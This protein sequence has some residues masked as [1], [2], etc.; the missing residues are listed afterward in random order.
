M[1]R[2]I[3]F[4]R[5][6][7]ALLL[8]LSMVFGLM[9]C[10]TP[11]NSAASVATTAPDNWP[12]IDP[13]ADPLPPP[14][15]EITDIV[16]DAT[17]GATQQQQD[18]PNNSGTQATQP[19][20]SKPTEPGNE[21][22]EQP[23]TGETQPGNTQPDDNTQ[24]GNNNQSGNNTQTE[25]VTPPPYNA[26][27]KVHFIDVGQADAALVVCQ[28]KTMLID[29]GNAADSNVMYAYLKKNGITHLDYV[30]G[31]HAHEDHIGG[32][33]G[34]LQYATVGKVY[35]PVTSYNSSAFRNFVQAVSNRGASITVP[36]VGTSFSLG[37]ASVKIIAVNTGS[38]PNNTSIVLRI[39]FG[40]TSFLFTGDAEYEVEQALVSSGATLKSTVLKVGHHGS[41]TSTKYSFLWHV[42]PEYAVI[43]VGKGNT[44]GHPTEDVLSRLRDAD[45]KLFRTDM[46]GDIICTSNGSS[47][48]F[49]VSRNANA[50]TFGGIGNNSTQTPPVQ[51]EPETQP[52][53][54]QP[55]DSDVTY[56]LNMG[57]M[58]FHEIYCE[59]AAKISAYNRFEFEGTR[60]EA[61]DMGYSPCGY[62][63]P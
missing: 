24:S 25:P 40:S 32:I 6:T 19:D 41:N 51:N 28:G 48:S 15:T 38:D 62:C 56:I 37:S 5:S 31:T 42:M 60:E 52:T 16:V 10:G 54:T 7:L 34:A 4:L 47:V 8:L 17:T 63:N 20:G 3:K 36:S 59:A 14:T 58:K 44:Y 18:G 13:T 61:I 11:E 27:L 57:S 9:G 35:C 33:P 43:S 1:K 39:T 29:G 22:T 46:Q 26:N 23:G 12:P 21:G 49:S 2:N 55:V 45:T 30:I 50:D 53:E